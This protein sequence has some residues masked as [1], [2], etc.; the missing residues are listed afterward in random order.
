[1]SLNTNESYR[2]HWPNLKEIKS[3]VNG[4]KI[5][6]EGMRTV[7]VFSRFPLLSGVA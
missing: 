2:K 6:Q 4:E 7:R 3:E 5:E 1:M